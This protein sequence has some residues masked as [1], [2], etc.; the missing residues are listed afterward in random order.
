MPAI[1]Y[2]Y[3]PAGPTLARFHRRDSFVRILLGPLGSA[4]STACCAEIW[5]R[6]SQQA[7]G[8]D[9]IRRSRWLVVRNTYPELITTTI[10]TW[11]E[12]FGDG[13]G[14]FTWGHPP[15]HR[16][17]VA[18]DDGSRVRAEVIFM[19]MDSGDAAKKLL[20]LEI[21]G[22]WLNELKELPK[23]VLD[24][25]TGRVGRYPARRAGGP[26]WFGII[27]DSNMPDEDHW[28]YR[29]AEEDRPAGWAFF[30]Q[31]GGVTKNADG[32]AVNPGAENSRNLPPDY[33]RNQLAGK[34]EDWIKVYLAGEYG[35]AFDGRAVFP[36]FI[37]RLHVQAF[38]IA[39][40]EAAMGV[41]FGLTPAAV[42][43][44]RD[45]RGRW[46][47]FDELVTEEM[48]A[49]RFAELVGERLRGPYG[50]LAFQ[51]W[52]D[53]AGE[54]RSQVDERTPFQVM[55]ARDIPIRPAPSNDAVIRREAAAGLLTRLIDGLPALWIHPRCKR[56]RKALAGG[57]CYRRVMVAGDERYRDVPDKNRHSHVAEALE[58]LLVG[59]G[60]GRTV[61]RKPRRDGQDLAQTA[62]M[63]SAL[64]F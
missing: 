39:G 30:R 62:D 63:S 6:A 24:M 23:A 8:G 19:A 9:G 5:R 27:C 48:G 59:A 47:I 4:K 61:V 44:Q 14:S 33:Y 38:E 20:S 1:E 55:Q 3:R 52:G 49:V 36:E 41:D 25:G 7:A 31:P 11:R 28:L 43:G 35:F 16:I 46:L 37:D 57:Y 26:G 32:W 58:Y 40:G 18:L 51:A 53:P 12:M 2:R 60:A 45:T 54:Q 22:L 21:T 34:S 13:F 56:L 42:F 15:R 29:L 10:A 64:D 50:H 17:D